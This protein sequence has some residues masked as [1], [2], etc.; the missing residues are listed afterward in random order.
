MTAKVTVMPTAMADEPELAVRLSIHRGA[1]LQ[2][3]TPSASISVELV[4]ESEGAD[5]YHG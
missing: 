1:R 4:D 5:R 3:A 2:P